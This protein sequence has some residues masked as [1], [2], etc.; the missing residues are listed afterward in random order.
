MRNGH[1]TEETKK[2][3]ST[4]QTEIEGSITTA[5]LQLVMAEN[6]LEE[7]SLSSDDEEAAGS[8]EEKTEAMHQ[9]EEKL[10]GVKAMQKLLNELLSK[11]QEEAVEKAA[12]N[13]RDSITVTFGDQNSGFQ[14]GNISGGVSGIN[15][16]R[17]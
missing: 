9:L 5:N 16:G 6:K 4:K 7:L 8:G 2:T 14:A 11:S 3:I 15:F 1:I 12:G 10:R 17:K 13:Q